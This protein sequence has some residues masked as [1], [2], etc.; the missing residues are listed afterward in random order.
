MGL[1]KFIVFTVLNA[2]SLERAIFFVYFTSS[3]HSISQ[4]SYLQVIF[5]LSIFLMEIPTGIFGDFY[6]KKISLAIGVLLKALSLFLQTVFVESYY[7][8]AFSFVL[9]SISFSFI[10]GSFYALIYQSMSEKGIEKLFPKFLTITMF[11]ESAS[12]GIAMALGTYIKTAL[13]WDSVYYATSLI[14][15]LSFPIIFKLSGESL[16]SINTNG[17]ERFNFSLFIKHSKQILP[18]VIPIS[19][20]HACMTPFFVNSQLLFMEYGKGLKI[21]GISISLVK[22]LSALFAI[23]LQ[24]HPMQYSKKN[25]LISVAIFTFFVIINIAGLYVISITSFLIINTL[26]INLLASLQNHVN[27]I[28]KDDSVRASALSFISF[29]DTIL[30]CS[31]YFLFAQLSQ[32][33]NIKESISMLGVFPL[34]ALI[35]LMAISKKHFNISSK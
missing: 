20:A 1:N 21:T 7:V 28:V 14:I 35:F 5:F 6:G 22:L 10:S 27:N 9:Y 16:K 19:L 18:V 24:M 26:V 8:L 12:L 29:I 11:F 30:I 25:V 31:G 23:G 3:G 17:R 32:Y 2:F 4:V 33:F 15:M 13:D 34:L